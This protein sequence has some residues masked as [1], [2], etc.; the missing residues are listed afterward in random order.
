MADADTKDNTSLAPEKVLEG[1]RTEIDAK[2]AAVNDQLA[3]LNQS[4]KAAAEAS[5][6]KKVEVSD[7]DIYQ[8]V[9]LKKKILQEATQM[10]N[11][12]LKA[13]REK[14][15]MIHSLSREYPEISSDPAMQKAVLAAQ[16]EIPTSIRDTAA[17]Y[18]MAVL[19]AVSK[20]GLVPKSKRQSE[21]NDE[22]ALNGSRGGN[23]ER[24]G[25]KKKVSEATL[26]FAQLL[27]RDVS[28]PKVVKGLE[29]AAN[30]D[31]YNRYR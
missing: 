16:A 20:A 30:R 3:A 12:I 15:L 24:T 27:G 8:P 18:E 17:G 22:F 10:T 1:I 7:D 19:K 11:E 13:D 2:L 25:G 23:R 14:A 5:T 28:D 6:T 21:S 9:E 4:F 26:A 31:T 29:E